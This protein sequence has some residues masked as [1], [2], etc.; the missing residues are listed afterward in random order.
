M[1][2]INAFSDYDLD[3]ALNEC[4]NYAKEGYL[5]ATE[6]ITLLTN[7]IRISSD[8]IQEEIYRLQEGNFD[9]RETTGKLI[10][11]L[12]N[13]RSNYELIPS[14][15]TDDVNTLN[16]SS[17]SI[18]LFGRTMAGKSTLM[19][20]LTKGKGNSIGKGKQRTTRDVR[21]YTYKSLKI[22]D[23][24]GVAAFEGEEDETVAFEAAQKSDLILFLITDDAPQASEAECLKRILEM[25][26]PVICL[27][28][29]KVDYC[30]TTS[31][32]MFSRDLNKR[33]A[34]ERLRELRE[35]FISFGLKFG[36][37]WHS[38]RFAFVH[39]KS[40]FMA[41]QVDNKEV[42]GE[43]LS[44]SRFSDLEKMIINEVCVNGGYYKFKSYLDVVGVP[45]LNA[46][47]TLFLQSA[48][49]SEQGSVLVDKSRKFREWMTRFEI[50]AKD[51]ISSFCIATESLLKKE[52]ASFAEYNY[53]NPNAK[54]E[55]EK[56]IKKHEIEAKANSLLTQL[57]DECQIQVA[58]IS[59]EI[60]TE[61]K[62]KNAFKVDSCINMRKV[63]D[64]KKICN[65]STTVISGV[66]GTGGMFF[67]PLLWA[68]AVVGVIGTI[69]SF[70]FTDKNKKVSEAR[71]DL[72]HK[73]CTQVEH[74]IGE[75][76]SNIETILESELIGSYLSKV[77]RV[78]NETIS[79]IFALS[80]T[81]RSMAISLNAKL[82]EINKDIV[83]QAL[84]YTD[85]EGLEWH[86]RE[87]ARIPGFA[88]IL[89]IE[90]GTV[91]PND[92]AKAISRLLKEK[93]WYLIRNKNIKSMLVQ[94]IWK[95]SDRVEIELDKIRIQSIHSVPLI[96]HIPFLGECDEFT[97]NR[98]R[99]A[100]QITE[101]LIMK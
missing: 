3:Q 51:R 36:Q 41:Q 83:K 4:K 19:E 45:L 60:Q 92:A 91:F 44:L 34:T 94:A 17:F 86:I 26:K 87:T 14:Q 30:P 66:L 48:Q 28:N 68:T 24:P 67:P 47:E 55:W 85:F 10:S 32:K 62:L 49:N 29:I 8:R 64:G 2:R 97:A 33:F 52:I 74:M 58:E 90:Y 16:K 13:I 9:D 89:V 71:T 5:K 35:A 96:A 56:I 23:V 7:T 40:A 72:E 101:L 78:L 75:L 27:V 84:K 63:V 50:D 37:D 46:F 38:L 69:G 42:S 61:L 15:L 6:A 76:K 11:Q 65:W 43:L 82:Q 1:R 20:I 93:V 88:T 25:G 57:S 99:M 54:K 12:S 21:T 98:I 80:E 59:R 70:L 81:Q 31:I 22:T 18:S 95:K 79:A 100:Q 77:N 53:D 73:L 39:L